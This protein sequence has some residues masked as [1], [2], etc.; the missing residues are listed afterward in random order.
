M[1]LAPS[2]LP[3]RHCHPAN[4]RYFELLVMR[5]AISHGYRRYCVLPPY[6]FGGLCPPPGP[7][8]GS[9]AR[10]T[11]E[12]GVE[13]RCPNHPGTR[14]RSPAP[15]L[16]VLRPATCLT[17]NRLHLL[18]CGTARWQPLITAGR[19]ARPPVLS[20]YCTNSGFK[21]LQPCRPANSSTAPR[22]FVSGGYLSTACYERNTNHT[23]HQC[24]LPPT[25]IFR[26][27]RR[28]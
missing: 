3:L 9:I 22:Q 7:V 14:A 11:H 12:P 16:G 26:R 15:L 10:P 21:T 2:V 18:N 8:A 20:P 17:A 23:P 19:P 13:P 4:C 27:P 24:L 25:Q 5:P 1:A 28:R 6:C